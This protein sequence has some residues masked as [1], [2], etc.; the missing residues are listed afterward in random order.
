M[1][2][3]FQWSPVRSPDIVN[4]VQT[5]ERETMNLF[6]LQ[7]GFDPNTTHVKVI[8]ESIDDESIVL[9]IYKFGSRKRDR[10]YYI[11][12]TEEIVT[13]VIHYVSEELMNTMSLGACALQCDFEIFDRV[14]KLI[15]KLDHVYIRE[16]SL[17]VVEDMVDYFAYRYPGYPGYPTPNEALE[18]EDYD[19]LVDEL[20][21]ESVRSYHQDMFMPF[22]VETYISVFTNK[23]LLGE[24]VENGK[25]T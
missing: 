25:E 22:T 14:D 18:S 7:H 24:V 6:L 3:E 15:Q 9:N 21:E 8:D 11:A 19:S 1:L 20:Y 23:Y 10:S 2:Y 12:T 5:P 16:T 17:S 13:S 4:Y